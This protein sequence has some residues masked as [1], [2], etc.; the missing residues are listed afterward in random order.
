M[1]EKLSYEVVYKTFN[2]EGCELLE[3]EYINNHTK[4]KYI[5]EC[6]NESEITYNKFQQ[7]RR[8]SK[9]GGNEKHNFEDVYKLFNDEGCELLETE[10]INSWTKMKYLCSCGNESK[11]KF[12]NFKKG[13]KCLQ[14]SGKEKHSYEQNCKK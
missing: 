6:G 7:N 12:N 3:T 10:Y 1:A 4:M 2:D 14:C 8:C 11:I 9:C 5:C 13:S